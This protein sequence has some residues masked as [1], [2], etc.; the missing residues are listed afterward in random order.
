MTDT[1]RYLRTYAK[2]VS[3]LPKHLKNDNKNNLNNYL[4]LHTL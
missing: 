3:V 1:A 4:N 2:K